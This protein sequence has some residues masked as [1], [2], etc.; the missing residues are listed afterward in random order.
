MAPWIERAEQGRTEY[1]IRFLWCIDG[2]IGIH[3]QEMVQAARVVP[4]S[5]RNDGV[6]QIPK[7]EPQ[8]GAILRECLGI[9]SGV[10]EDPLSIKV[11][12][13]REAPI[14]FQGRCLAK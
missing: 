11:Q 1:A 2:Q 10:K 7:V 9:V 12:M 13:C 8:G 5:V 4:M 6:I 14:L 3:L